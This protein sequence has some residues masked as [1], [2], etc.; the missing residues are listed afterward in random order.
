MGTL[1]VTFEGTERVKDSHINRLLQVYEM[2]KMKE[3]KTISEMYGRFLE[4]V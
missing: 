1:M 3:G 2:V 4:I